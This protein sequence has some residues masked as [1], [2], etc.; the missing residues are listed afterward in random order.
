MTGQLS[1]GDIINLV[2]YPSVFCVVIIS[3]ITAIVVL[4]VKIHMLL[5]KK[6]KTGARNLIFFLLVVLFKV[7]LLVIMTTIGISKSLL[8]LA[9]VEPPSNASAEANNEAVVKI[10]AGLQLIIYIIGSIL[11][12]LMYILLAYL[13][14]NMVHVCKVVE[15]TSTRVASV[16]RIVA[17]GGTG[18]L[19][20]SYAFTF[21]SFLV[22]QIINTSLN[23]SALTIISMVVGATCYLIMG[24]NMVLLAVLLMICAVRLVQRSKSMPAVSQTKIRRVVIILLVLTL[25]SIIFLISQILGVVG[26]IVNIFDYGAQFTYV[27]ASAADLVFTGMLIVIHGQMRRVTAVFKKVVKKKSAATIVESPADELNTL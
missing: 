5:G 26:T 24:I 8:N 9:I 22:L 25:I 20:L 17:V 10:I 7:V 23:N 1:A 14:Y 21:I 27:V 6:E 13:V 2:V 18:A 4:S 11:F 19:Q 12:T 15:A 16:I 3:W